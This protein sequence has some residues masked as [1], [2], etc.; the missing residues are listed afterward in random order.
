MLWKTCHMLSNNFYMLSKD[1]NTMMCCLR[2]L[3]CCVKL[4]NIFF[5][6]GC[7]RGSL[8][9]MP[10]PQRYLRPRKVLAWCWQLWQRT[11]RSCRN[12]AALRWLNSLS[13]TRRWGTASRTRVAWLWTKKPVLN[14]RTRN[15]FWICGKPLLIHSNPHIL[16]ILTISFHKNCTLIVLGLLTYFESGPWHES[17]CIYSPHEI[18]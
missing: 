17:G 9:G 3:I 4:D 14:I 5:R 13:L 6:R 10:T 7:R 2:D 1:N 18:T 11:A 16:G 8:P 12:R 15:L